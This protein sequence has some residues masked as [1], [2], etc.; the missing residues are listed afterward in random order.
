MT[1]VEESLRV[2]TLSSPVTVKLGIPI[3]VLSKYHSVRQQSVTI[4]RQILSNLL[5]ISQLKPNY[6]DSSHS[7]TFEFPPGNSNL[8]VK[9]SNSVFLVMERTFSTRI[10]HS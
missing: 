2:L 3:P 9:F 7:R 8:L 6:Y 5:Q 10:K 4:T 1:D